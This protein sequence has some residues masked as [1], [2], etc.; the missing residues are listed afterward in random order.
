MRLNPA[1]TPAIP[2]AM[3]TT[4]MTD[5]ITDTTATQETCPA[6]PARLA[7]KSRH[8]AAPVA[9]AFRHGCGQREGC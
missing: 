2:A 8:V 5:L 7:N 3:L 9:A 6:T 1:G 4:V